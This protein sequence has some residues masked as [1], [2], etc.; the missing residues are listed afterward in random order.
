LVIAVVTCSCSE[1][2]YG[3]SSFTIRHK[4]FNCR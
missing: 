3:V 1:K 4:F 2:I